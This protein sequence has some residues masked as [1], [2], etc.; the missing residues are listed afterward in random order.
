MS[1]IS[2]VVSSLKNNLI[3]YFN[4]SIENQN[5][6]L[7]SMKPY[8]TPA[9]MH[10]NKR[11]PLDCDFAIICYCPQP[12][13]FDQYKVFETSWMSDSNGMNVENKTRYFIHS[14]PMH[15][16]FCSYTNTKGKRK[17]FIVISEVY[18]VAMSTT[19]IEELV[20]Y[21]IDDIIGVGFVGAFDH[22]LKIGDNIYA[23]KA[24]IEEGLKS[25]E[26]YISPYIYFDPELITS[27]WV[28]V[29]CTNTLYQEY[30]HDIL[31][32]IEKGCSVVNM[33]T[34]HFYLTTKQLDCVASYYATVS[35]V[36]NIK[37]DNEEKDE[38]DLNSDDMKEAKEWTNELDLSVNG[39]ESIVLKNQ[40]ILIQ[41][42]LEQYN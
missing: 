2:K 5:R 23:K 40:S 22:D 16:I 29:W 41:N 31:K 18:G 30:H 6:E 14:H 17:D 26:I 28:T 37:Q 24:L 21:G 20:F 7:Q 3:S 9:K 36:I 32:A 4:P 25:T 39:E 35:D 10:G 42:L 8:I 11:L 34:S 38:D 33:D 13:I 12:K 19:T 27:K 1:I 15:V